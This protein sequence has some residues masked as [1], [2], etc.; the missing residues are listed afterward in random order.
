MENTNRVPTHS[1]QPTEKPM[2]LLAPPRHTLTLFGIVTVLVVAGAFNASHDATISQVPDPARMIKNDVIMIGMLWLWV[3][4]VFKGM[5]DYG[6]SI[7][8]F[9]GWE[10]LTL[11]E[12]FGDLMVV[13][14]AFVLIYASASGVH[15]LLPNPAINNPLLSATPHGVE[16]AV[17][18][19][20]LSIS[21]GICEEI[22]FRGY[23]QRQLSSMTGNVGIAIVVQAIVFGIGHV[24][25]GLTSVSAIVLHGLV[26]GIVA[27][28]RGNIRAGIV[29]HAGWDI[30][31]GF[32]LIG[33][34]W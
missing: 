14:L 23:L 4:F 13:S 27:Q 5:Q 29:E 12:L 11:R 2:T 20:G 3:Y 7:L 24:Y 6:Q 19:I 30:L 1:A 8:Q 18:W 21:A 16:G 31:A 33:A 10:S 28:W 34:N 25:E 17:V 15:A 26:L 32:G 9:F 22:V